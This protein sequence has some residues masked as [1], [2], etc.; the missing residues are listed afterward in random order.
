[1]VLVIV[2]V[3]EEVVHVNDEPSFC[4]HIPKRIGHELLK[5]GEGIGHAEEHDSGFIEPVV[6]NEGSFPLVALF[7]MDIVVSPSYMKLHKDLD[8]LEFV[9]KV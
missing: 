1:M 7:D 9:N 4:N 6:G 5:S 8:I 3:D 2:Q